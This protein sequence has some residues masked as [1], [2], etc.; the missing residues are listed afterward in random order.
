VRQLGVSRCGASRT[1]EMLDE[2]R[3]QLDLPPIE[4]QAGSVAGY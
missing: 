1:K 3:K 4:F 2:C